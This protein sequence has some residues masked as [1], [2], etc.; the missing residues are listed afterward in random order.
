MGVDANG[1][2]PFGKR[3]ANNLLTQ[4]EYPDGIYSN[5]VR[6]LHTK[7]LA[8]KIAKDAGVIIPDNIGRFESLSEINEGELPNQ[9]VIKPQWG[10][11]NNGVMLLRREGSNWHDLMRGITTPWEGLISIFDEESQEFG[12]ISDAVLV[13]RMFNSREASYPVPLDYKMYCFHGKVQLIM[14]R[15]VNR[16]RHHSN[17]RYQYWSPDGTALGKVRSGIEVDSNLQKPATFQQL[18]DA[19][20]KISSS[21]PIPFIRIDLYDADDGIAFGEFTVNPGSYQAYNQEWDEKLGN[22]YGVGEQYSQEAMQDFST[23]LRNQ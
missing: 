13:E 1:V 3:I 16:G 8:K 11:F 9:V 6:L 18:I 22:E 5:M 2:L 17:W 7:H 20:E 4:K 21:I 10:S 12:N 15:D 23:Y 19:A 14:Q